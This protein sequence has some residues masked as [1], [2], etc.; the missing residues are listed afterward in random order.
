M[1]SLMVELISRLEAM[2]RASLL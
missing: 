1:I 2:H